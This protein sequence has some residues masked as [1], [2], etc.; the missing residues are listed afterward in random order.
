ME[1]TTKPI[2]GYIMLLVEFIIL[3]GTIFLFVVSHNPF[4]LLTGLFFFLLIMPGFFYVNPNSSRVLVLFGEYKG[5][6]KSNGFFWVNP[7][8]VKKSI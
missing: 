5:T 6:V 3:S 4:A 2:S 7:F 1:R 8:F